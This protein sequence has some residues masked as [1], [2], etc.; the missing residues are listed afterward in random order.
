MF[1]LESR[2]QVIYDQL[3]IMKKCSYN[4]DFSFFKMSSFYIVITLNFF[5]KIL[6]QKQLRRL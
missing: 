6:Q 3:S 5:N 2:L 4:I 1:A